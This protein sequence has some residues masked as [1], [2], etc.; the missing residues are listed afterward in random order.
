MSPIRY[1]VFDGKVSATG[2]SVPGGSTQPCC[3]PLTVTGVSWVP[4]V[5]C[6]I[7]P[8]FTLSGT[9]STREAADAATFT[10]R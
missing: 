2:P 6:A 1:G 7:Q 10:S 5:L 9:T 8:G 4:S 3:Q